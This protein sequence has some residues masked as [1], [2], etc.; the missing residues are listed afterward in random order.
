MGLALASPGYVG[1]AGLLMDA[2]SSVGTPGELP[3]LARTVIII[4]VPITKLD[5]FL[6]FISLT[7]NGQLL[8][9][10]PQL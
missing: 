2:P 7:L 5:R 4:S 3:Y 1:L 9:L 10:S 8:I 6:C